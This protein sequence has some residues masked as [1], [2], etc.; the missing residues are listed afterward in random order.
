MPFRRKVAPFISP[1]CWGHGRH[2]LLSVWYSLPQLSSG[3]DSH[4]SA[5]GVPRWVLDA[6][7]TCAGAWLLLGLTGGHVCCAEGECYLAVLGMNPGLQ[8][9]V[10]TLSTH[11]SSLKTLPW[12]HSVFLK[13]WW[14]WP[15]QEPVRNSVLKPFP[16]DW[17][18]ESEGQ[19]PDL[20]STP[21][22]GSESHWSLCLPVV[23]SRYGIWHLNHLYNPGHLLKLFG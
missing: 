19:T 5:V 17:V 18:R 1:E 8:S 4:H 21:S 11:I 9:S 13:V 16:S 12:Q 20:C 2:C 3:Y 6:L 10:L 23:V 15:P 22:D 14:Q 7:D